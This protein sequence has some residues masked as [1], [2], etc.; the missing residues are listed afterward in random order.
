MSRKV[1]V[2]GNINNDE[3]V[4][5]FTSSNT[6]IIDKS[7]D[8]DVIVFT[9]DSY[10]FDYSNLR[11]LI[12]SD[13]YESLTIIIGGKGLVDEIKN[14]PSDVYDYPGYLLYLIQNK[15]Y[16]KCPN[17]KKMIDYEMM[18]TIKT[19]LNNDMNITV[20]AKELFVHRNTLNYRLDKFHKEFDIDLRT[21]KGCFALYTL[22]NFVQY[23]S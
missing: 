14:I 15:L 9:D 13:Y 19:Y 5:I 2:Y 1:Y 3:L 17:I 22:L 6:G 21:F 23:D 18:H 7:I 16:E 8:G 20:T 11:D 4:E 12:E 10:D